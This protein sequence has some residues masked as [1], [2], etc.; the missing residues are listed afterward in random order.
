[1]LFFFACGKHDYIIVHCHTVHCKVCFLG[2][3]VNAHLVVHFVDGACYVVISVH[4]VDGACHVVI[5]VPHVTSVIIGL[6]QVLIMLLLL[7]VLLLLFMVFLVLLTFL[8]ATTIVNH[9]VGAH[10]VTPSLCLVLPLFLHCLASWR[11]IG[12]RR[13]LVIYNFNKNFY[14]LGMFDF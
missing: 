9:V 11:F 4:Y 7:L 1:M 12:G 10:C 14:T 6:L 5:N 13:L 2:T 3:F 8:H